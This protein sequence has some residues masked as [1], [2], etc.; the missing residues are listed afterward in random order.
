MREAVRKESEI[1]SELVEICTSP[2]YVHAISYLCYQ[3]DTIGYADTL[4][5]EEM[6]HQISRDFLVRTEI[7]T[8]V[9]L[10]CKKQLNIDLPSPEVIQRYIDK[11]NSLLKELHQSMMPPEESIFDPSKVND[12]SFNPLKNG[13]VLREA[14]FYSGESA[15]HF[16]Y[17]DLSKIKYEKDND[18]FLRNK[19]FSIQQV[20]D[21]VIS[22]QS[23]QNDKVNDFLKSL[24]DRD[25][26]EWTVFPAYKFTAREVSEISNIEIDTVKLVIESFV[27]PIGKD[28]FNALD[29]FNPQNA[30]PIIQLPDGEYLLFQIYSLVQALYETPFFWFNDDAA[31]RSI[32]M[33]HRGGFTENFSAERLKLV[34]GKDRV[35]TNI[36]I[37]NSK[38]KAGEIDVLVVFADRA[39]I[40]QAKSKK[41]TIA[42]R[43][44]NDNSLQSDFK[45]AIQDAYDQAYSCA[46]LLNEKNYKLIDKSGNELN[47]N[48][49]YKEIYP[50]CVISEHYP[51]LSFQARLFL[52]FEETE[53]IK[54]PFVMDVFL[55]DVMTEMLQSPLYFLS[56]VNRRTFYGEK[57]FSTHELTILSYHL[58]QSLWVDDEYT[59]L[60][61]QDDICV[62][63]YLAMLTRR[64]G[65]PG[66]DTPE[67][68]LT[69]YK[70][71]IFDQIIRDYRYA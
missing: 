38:D 16:Q 1:F 32:A 46:K 53:N 14:I 57:I 22:I 4:T 68:I 62:D 6:L 49:A 11:T 3:N 55:L 63:L 18:W 17:R 7:S 20:I 31:Y 30:Y 37:Y 12:K 36:D 8:L 24:S 33:D 67:G 9:G 35:F 26:S 60:M 56:Y 2:G 58:K 29:D 23:I 66:S 41:L 70:G 25:P 34:F 5:P 52:K 61:L 42:S 21:V 59:W 69:K 15:Y 65:A 43:K 45:K 13:L 39:I 10:A 51:A 27:S 64:E 40:L 19:R 28:E 47:I 54:A 50:F 44:G 71:T 48:R